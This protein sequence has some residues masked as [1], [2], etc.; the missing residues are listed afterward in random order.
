MFEQ[1]P[2][3]KK[4][5]VTIEFDNAGKWL[6]KP[7]KT[8]AVRFRNAAGAGVLYKFKKPHDMSFGPDSKATWDKSQVNGVIRIHLGGVFK[9]NKLARV[10]YEII[11]VK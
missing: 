3:V 5:G 8:A 7:C 11:P 2:F 1:L 6:D 9:K 10:Q 4:S